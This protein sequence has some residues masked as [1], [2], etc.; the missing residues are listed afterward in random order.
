MVKRKSARGLRGVTRLSVMSPC[1]PKM[2]RVHQLTTYSTTNKPSQ[3]LTQVLATQE[4]R[5]KYILTLEII[6]FTNFLKD[7]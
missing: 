3:V 5:P 6:H 4:D 2:L 7:T 1:T